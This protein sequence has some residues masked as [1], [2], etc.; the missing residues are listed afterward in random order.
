MGD[1]TD[2]DAYYRLSLLTNLRTAIALP[3]RRTVEPGDTPM[4]AIDPATAQLAL[5]VA[6]RS[7]GETIDP[8][9]YP[10]MIV[11]AVA[12][13]M[14]GDCPAAEAALA[15]VAAADDLAGHGDAIKVR[16]AF[17]DRGIL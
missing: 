1:T 3:W 17:E 8:A 16:R 4:A 11:R 7:A 14:V 12:A 10:A 9:D 6:R 2:A 13:R 15:T 5:L